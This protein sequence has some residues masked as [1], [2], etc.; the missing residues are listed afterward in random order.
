MCTPEFGHAKQLS[1]LA[2]DHARRRR[3]VRS[4]LKIVQRGEDRSLRSRAAGHE[5]R[6]RSS[7]RKSNGSAGDR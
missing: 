7:K 2:D 5:Q 4:P 3:P 6:Q 1:I